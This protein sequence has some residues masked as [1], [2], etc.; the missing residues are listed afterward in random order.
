MKVY[1]V[2]G[3]PG[4]PKLLTIKAKEL[5]ENCQCCVYAGSLVS[6]EVL[7]IIPDSAEKHD[8]AAMDL[9]QIVDVFKRCAESGTDVVR[10]HSGDPSIFGAI[11]EQMN[12]L[13]KLEIG[14]EVIP[15]VSSFQAAAAALNLELTAPE[16]SQTVILTRTAGRTPVPAEQDL[17]ELAKTHATLCLFLSV[18]NLKESAEKLAAHYGA[19]CPAAVVSRASWPD[20]V[21]LQGTLSDIAEKTKAA[22]I[23]KTA[24]VIAGWALSRD[25]PASRLYAADFSHGYRRAE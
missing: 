13:D 9:N 1:F 23:S 18:H 14:Y 3:G 16:V 6:A 21:I 4:D 8:S 17:D 22:G 24:M 5:L 10:L 25:I 15:G 2:G 11:R 12:E 20:Q 19:D 7:A